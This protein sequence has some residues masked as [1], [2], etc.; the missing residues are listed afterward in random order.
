MPRGFTVGIDAFNIAMPNG[1]G[2]A[3]YS[4]NLN[5]GLRA[6]GV[7]TGILYGPDRTDRHSALLNQIA[8]LD[9]RSARGAPTRARRAQITSMLFPLGRSARQVE[10]SGEVLT[11]SVA[12]KM[13]PS[14]D[15]W[16]SRD[17]FH[18]ANRAFAAT[19]AFTPLTMN[20]GGPDVMHWTCA[21]PLRATRRANL[22]TLHDLV[23]LRLPYA[24]LDNK[25]RFLALTRRIC[26]RADC[27]VTVSERSKSDIVKIFGTDPDRIFV[28]HQAVVMPE[29]AEKRSEAEAAGELAGIFG[30]EWRGYFLFFGAIEPKKNLAR[31]IEAYLAS[32][33]PTPLVIVGGRVWLDDAEQSMLALNRIAVQNEEKAERRNRIRRYGFVPQ[34]LLVSLIRGARATLMPSLYEGFGLPVLESMVLGTPVLAST[35][36]SLPEVAGDAALLVDPYDA[37][38]IGSAIRRL[39]ADPGLRDDLAARGLAQARKFSPEVYQSRLAELYRPFR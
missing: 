13:P 18:G 17:V 20:E 9:A 15:I 16:V 31:L 37:L 21:L 8:I 33:I 29:E 25:R 10:R 28:T 11:A 39:D 36:G 1:T 38:A 5:A 7:R 14:D 19:G 24:T 3:T 22:Y 4:R 34:P 35:T 12:L 26:A 32:G 6:I 2:I 27:V 30:L 23:P